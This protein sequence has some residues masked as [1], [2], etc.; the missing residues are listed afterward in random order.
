AER[1]ARQLRNRLSCDGPRSS[2]RPGR[3]KR[4]A[5]ALARRPGPASVRKP[6][7]ARAVP[8]AAPRRPP[9]HA[10][11]RPRARPAPL[12]RRAAACPP[13]REPTAPVARTDRRRRRPLPIR[14]RLPARGAGPPPMISHRLS[15]LEQLEHESIHV[16]REVAAEFRNPV[17]L[18]SIGKDSAVML[19]LAQKAFW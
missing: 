5:G 11:R 19:R 14:P 3:E 1:G 4:T 18:F 12:P 10:V 6:P 17:M 16:I 2:G 9:S 15:H 7:P 13:P 8:R